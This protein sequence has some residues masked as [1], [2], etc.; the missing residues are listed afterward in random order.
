MIGV[1]WVWACEGII[2]CSTLSDI[3]L[4]KV[5]IFG[6]SLRS[7]LI[8]FDG[9]ILL[10]GLFSCGAVLFVVIASKETVV[11]EEV[12]A[13]ESAELIVSLVLLDV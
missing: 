6:S 3:T 12:R 9:L 13:S 8:L 2:E 1:F 11:I 10:L 7:S 5:L 4:D